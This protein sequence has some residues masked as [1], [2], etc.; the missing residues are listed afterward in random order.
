MKHLRTRTTGKGS[1]VKTPFNEAIVMAK[2]TEIMKS[3]EVQS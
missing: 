1:S 3:E 2:D